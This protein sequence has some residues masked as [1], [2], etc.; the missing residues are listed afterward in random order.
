MNL[1]DSPGAMA[2]ELLTRAA[3]MIEKREDQLAGQHRSRREDDVLFDHRKW[4][5]DYDEYEKRRICLI[6]ERLQS[7][8]P[9]KSQPVRNRRRSA[10]K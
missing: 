7:A 6:S 8:T 5:D 10:N 9:P 2:D 1:S 4:L 3:E